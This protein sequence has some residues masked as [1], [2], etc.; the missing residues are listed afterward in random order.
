MG[1]DGDRRRLL[2]DLAVAVGLVALVVVARLL[3]HLPNF[4]PVA[5]VALFSAYYFRRRQWAAAIPV[6]GMIVADF[7]LPQYA[8]QQRLVVY[9]AFAVCYVVGLVLRK[10][11]TL[12]RTVVAS[13]VASAVFFLITNCVFLYYGPGPVM[14]SHT[15]AGQVHSYVNALPF[16]RWT[17]LGDLAYSL[18]IFAAYQYACVYF[19]KRKV[20]LDESTK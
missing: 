20:V 16:L 6:A 11:Y 18:V 4:T 7:F 8:W 15:L 13:L 5:A 3:P 12:G 1:V 2:I 17:V 14:Y 9:G 10:K 19:N